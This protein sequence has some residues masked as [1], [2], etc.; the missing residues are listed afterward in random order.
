MNKNL[1]LVITLWSLLL[2]SS[3]YAGYGH[4]G[5]V[6]TKL[7]AGF[8]LQ[9]N[10]QTITNNGV[11]AVGKDSGGGLLAGVGLGYYFMDELRVDGSFYYDRGMKTKK[12]VRAGGFDTT[13]RAKEQSFGGFANAYF[14]VL[15]SSNITPYVMGGVGFFRNEFKTEVTVQGEGVGKENKSKFGMGY[16]AGAGVSYHLSSNFDLD[17]GYRYIK[18]G[19]KEYK[20]RIESLDASVV[21]KT[22]P[23]H[24]A[25]IG[26]R[27]TF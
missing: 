11:K 5:K 9:D 25:I 22:G 21:A 13:M 26:I 18:K 2:S 27:S 15:N 16:Q 14:D 19:S 1:T 24:A 23:V 10:E 17:F 7:D 12:T 8:G 6:Y 4:E 3:A 20:F